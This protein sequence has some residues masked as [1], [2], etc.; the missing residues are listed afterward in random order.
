MISAP[1][2]MPL[3]RPM[4]VPT[5]ETSLVRKPVGDH[6]GGALGGRPGVVQR[7]LVD[8][9]DVELLGGL[10]ERLVGDVADLVG[11]LGHAPDGGDDDA[12]H[13][14][15]RPRTIRPA[16]RVGLSLCRWRTPTSG[17]KMMAST[18]ANV[19]GSTISLTAPSAMTT[20]TAAATNPTKL[21]DQMPSFGIGVGRG[22][23]VIGRRV[24]VRSWRVVGAV[25]VGLGCD[26][27]G[28]GHG[29]SASCASRVDGSGRSAAV[30]VVGALERVAEAELACGWRERR[31]R[32][33]GQRLRTRRRG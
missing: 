11:L 18:A 26:V 28:V 5:P 20:M 16:A 23:A 2:M 9:G 17:L 14:A 6:R 19:I 13:Q 27:G 7:G 25:A 24:A 1:R 30:S 22:R 29:T 33:G 21:H 15:S 31:A 3:A 4:M 8:A 12:G 10:V 32:A